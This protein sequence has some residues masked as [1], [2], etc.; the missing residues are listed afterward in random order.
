MSPTRRMSTGFT[1][2]TLGRFLTGKRRDKDLTQ[3]EMAAFLHTSRA[4]YSHLESGR[5]LDVL[6]PD[7][8]NT[9]CRVLGMSMFELLVAEGFQL[10]M[11]EGVQNVQEEQILLAYRRLGVEGRRLLLQALGV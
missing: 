7:V 4:N 2:E 1:A 9:L 10:T 8:C 3:D 11:P 6:T 5:R